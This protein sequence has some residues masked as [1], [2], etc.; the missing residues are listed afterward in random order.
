[1]AYRKISDEKWREIEEAVERG[2]KEALAR[3]LI[4]VDILETV[5]REAAEAKS[6]EDDDLKQKDAEEKKAAETPLELAQSTA[7]FAYNLVTYDFPIED[8]V[9]VANKYARDF[10]L[11][12]KARAHLVASVEVLHKEHATGTMPAY[13]EFARS[14]LAEDQEVAVLSQ[15]DYEAEREGDLLG[16]YNERKTAEKRVELKDADPSDSPYTRGREAFER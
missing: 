8:A 9:A 4:P 7:F 5:Y 3:L 14:F 10:G 13:A 15:V 2:D 1:M 11:G 16:E 6:R 12:D